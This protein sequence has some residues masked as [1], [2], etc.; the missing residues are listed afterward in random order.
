LTDG[1]HLGSPQREYRSG[2]DFQGG[3]FHF[4]GLLV[5]IDLRHRPHN[6]RYKPVSGDGRDQYHAVVFSDHSPGSCS[7]GY[8]VTRRG[9]SVPAST[10]HTVRTMGVRPLGVGNTPSIIYFRPWSDVMLFVTGK[11]RAT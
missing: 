8:A 11:S 6:A 9:V 3:Q 4:V 1:A 5:T 7:F 2:Y 10:I